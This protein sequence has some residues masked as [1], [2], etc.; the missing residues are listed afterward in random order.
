[1]PFWD[2]LPPAVAGILLI[3]VVIFVIKKLIK[4]A[5][6]AALVA[7]FLVVAWNYGLL[8]FISI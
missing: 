2:A 5:V 3:V 7:V 6:I 8:K 4:L 1:M